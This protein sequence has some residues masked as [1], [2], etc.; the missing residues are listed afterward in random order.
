VAL[1]AE[2]IHDPGAVD[3]DRDRSLVLRYQR[4]DES[5]F[6]ELYR[7]YYPRLHQYCQRRVGDTHASEELAQEAFLKALR[8]MPRFAGERRFYPWMTVIA[9]RLCIDHHRRTSRVE[10][11]A[12]IDLGVVEAD[13]DELYA[14]VDRDH[15]TQAMARLAPRHREVLG[16]RE[17]KGWSYQQIAEHLDVP[18]TT[19]EALL[20]RARKA[21]KREFLAVSSGGRLAGMPVVGWLVF[22][23]ARL[24]AKVTG[25]TASQL[26]PIAGSAAAGVAAIGLVLNPLGPTPSLPA[27][28]RPPA[29]VAFASPS[30]PAPS[31]ISIAEPATPSV[32]PAAAPPRVSTPA[33]PTPPVAAAGPVAVYS[34]SDGTQQAQAANAEQPLQ[35]DLA[36]IEAGLN[37]VQIVHDAA[38]QLPGGNP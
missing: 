24:R 35:V 33:V 30:K 28:S 20:H 11:S 21:L 3:L 16:L 8:A 23:M 29:A 17:T 14:E 6:D 37:P 1:R 7:R 2:E 10:P 15:L 31:T 19:V 5:A 34:G 25:K 38:N 22:R 32:A 27:L 4:G 9:Q 12:D 13:H 18:L 26:A 36:V